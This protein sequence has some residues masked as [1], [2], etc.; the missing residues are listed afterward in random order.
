MTGHATNRDLVSALR[1]QSVKAGAEA[2]AVRGADWRLATV[3]A[4]ATDGTITA[5]GIDGIRRME[6]YLNPAVGDVVR[7]DQSSSGNWLAMGRLAIAGATNWTPYTP[8]WTSTGTAPAV[9]N[10]SIVGRFQRFGRTIVCGINLIPGSTT[11]FGTGNY[12]LSLPVT[13]ASSGMAL[14]GHAQ[15]LASGVGSTNNRFEG[16]VVISSGSTTCS[17]F[18]PPSETNVGLDFMSPTQPENFHSG[19]QLR[20]TLMYEAAT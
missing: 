15:Y 9:V 16:Q 17:P 6:S 7:I 1:R 18:F 3:T 12:S 8:A 11:T 13:A 19:D 14:L 20:L 10:G 2:P 4:V 5:D